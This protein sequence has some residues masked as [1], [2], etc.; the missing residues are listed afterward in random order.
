MLIYIY[1]NLYILGNAGI[2]VSNFAS[3]VTNM[4]QTKHDFAVTMTHANNL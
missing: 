3:Y 2:V 4:P 1:Y